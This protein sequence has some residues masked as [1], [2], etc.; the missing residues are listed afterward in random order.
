MMDDKQ[1]TITSAERIKMSTAVINQFDDARVRAEYKVSSYLARR[2]GR[3]WMDR[4]QKDLLIK[5]MTAQVAKQ[6]EHIDNADWQPHLKAKMTE[7]VN[8]KF[9]HFKKQLEKGF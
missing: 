6:L 5:K 3:K 1:R 4:Q 9:T 2:W 7:V 8:Q